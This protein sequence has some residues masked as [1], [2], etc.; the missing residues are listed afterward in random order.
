MI[1]NILDALPPKLNSTD[2]VERYRNGTFDISNERL[3]AELQLLS[4]GDFVPLSIK[5]DTW[6][7][8]TQVQQFKED[9]FPY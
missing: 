7:F 5:L 9:W 4:L 8:D 3:A 6:L 1:N 2:W